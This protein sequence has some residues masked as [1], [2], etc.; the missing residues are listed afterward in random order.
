MTETERTARLA[1][2][3]DRIHTL[4]TA[5][6]L[7]PIVVR[8]A[9]ADVRAAQLRQGFGRHARPSTGRQVA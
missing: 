5:L 9:L 7:P 2:A 8:T 1:N 3:T 4:A 6:N